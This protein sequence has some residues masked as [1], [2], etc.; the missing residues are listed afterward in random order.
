MQA[1]SN[2]KQPSFP[3]RQLPLRAPGIHVHDTTPTGPS[4]EDEIKRKVSAYP[5]LN[6]DLTPAQIKSWARRHPAAVCKTDW[7]VLNRL[8]FL[9]TR[10]KDH[11]F[12]KVS[13]Q[14]LANRLGV[15][16]LTIIRR[17]KWLRGVNA[18]SW[19]NQTNAK[20][21]KIA[22]EF[23][24]ELDSS[25]P[26]NRTNDTSHVSPPCNAHVSDVTCY[27]RAYTTLN[28]SISTT[29]DTRNTLSAQ[30]PH[31]RRHSADKTVRR[32][33]QPLSQGN[34]AIAVI[35][36]LEGSKFK[37]D[38]AFIDD[39]AAHWKGVDVKTLIVDLAEWY[40]EHPDKRTNRTAL[41]KDWQH[42]FPE[43]LTRNKYKQA[44]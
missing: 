25:K 34:E 15:S 19:K 41:I 21:G 38:Q 10:D 23:F 9:L 14:G 20:G 27:A 26:E 24:F 2:T 42:R 29:R 13:H 30:Q 8:A 17:L 5:K 7:E 39:F 44:E 4:R 35:C 18:L 28:D 6:L 1:Q 11:P 32:K 37:V 3:T 36:C 40:Q 43:W 22:N 12:C 31:G 16:R 33:R